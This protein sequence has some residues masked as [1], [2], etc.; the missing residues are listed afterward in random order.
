MEWDTITI[1]LPV[2]FLITRE[3]ETQKKKH[4]KMMLRKRFVNENV[5]Y[6][7]KFKGNDEDQHALKQKQGYGPVHTPE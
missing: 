4:L 1:A 5:E 6:D 7:S 2:W 3:K